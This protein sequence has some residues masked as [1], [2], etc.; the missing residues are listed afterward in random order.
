[1]DENIRNIFTSL[2]ARD[3]N[4]YHLT[5]VFVHLGDVNS[6][7]YYILIRDFKKDCW[8]KF[9]DEL[10]T[11]VSE[12][13]VMSDSTGEGRNVYM[14]T[15]TSKTSF[16]AVGVNSDEYRRQYLERWPDIKALIPANA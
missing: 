1:M 16:T 9:N 14:L 8:V 10:I 3:T 7:H 6:G 13:E 11:N 4:P 12:E 15:Y 5:A 2:D